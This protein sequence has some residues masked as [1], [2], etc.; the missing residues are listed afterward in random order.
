MT[1]KQKELYY[2]T[3]QRSK[4][5]LT[6]PESA[7][8]P[9]DDILDDDDLPK[10]RGKK[11]PKKAALK[12]TENSSNVLMDLRKAANHPMLFRR[13]FDNDT[14]KQMSI[15]C[16]KEVEYMD[17]DPKYIEEDMDLMTDYELHKF[18][19]PFKVR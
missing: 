18:V 1:T 16:L 2:E 17:K 11:P 6:D 14:I 12:P 7:S 5:A 4:K 19:Q 15:D 8:T 9:I 13:L 10:K 3:L